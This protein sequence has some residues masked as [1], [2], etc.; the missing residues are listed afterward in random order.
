[1]S[2]DLVR[3]L[4]E[5]AK[6]IKDIKYRQL[7]VTIPTNPVTAKELLN[8]IT[9]DNVRI[10]SGLS[11]MQGVV[12]EK[13]TPIKTQI[14]FL[15][16]LIKRITYEIET[17]PYSP[18]YMIKLCVS[19]V[20]IKNLITKAVSKLNNKSLLEKIR[21]KTGLFKKTL[22]MLGLASALSSA[23]PKSIT[24]AGNTM[25]PNTNNS[26]LITNNPSPLI[27]P[28]LESKSMNNPAVDAIIN[29]AQQQLG[30][31]Y[32]W[33]ATG[34]NAFDCSGF[35]QYV[36]G[37]HSIEMPRVSSEQARVGDLICKG[38]LDTTRMMPG[39]LIF[40]SKNGRV[41][42]VGIYVGSKVNNNGEIEIIMVH[43]P[44]ARKTVRYERVD[45]KYWLSQKPEVRRVLGVNQLYASR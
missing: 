3:E 14:E 11:D 40:F 27:K 24:P 41:H 8:G 6:N 12:P 38:T 16:N 13:I 7:L 22:I 28:T 39:D 9:Q 43:A 34:P 26:S 31:P 23:N 19:L 33:G 45:K 21:D 1:M 25:M 17:A 15:Q 10:L 36:Y 30:K 29:T 44:S 18:E 5:V 35:V 42:H 32:I 20:Q 2:I 4:N 37:K